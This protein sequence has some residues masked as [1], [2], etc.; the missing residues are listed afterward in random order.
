MHMLVHMFVT[1]CVCVS[2]FVIVCVCVCVRVMCVYMYFGMHRYTVYC[3][4]F[5]VEKF[6]GFRG[7]ISDCKAFPVKQP[8]QWALATK[9]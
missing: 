5:T 7:L 4:S 2:M 9:H 1:V 8:V 3:E 6:R